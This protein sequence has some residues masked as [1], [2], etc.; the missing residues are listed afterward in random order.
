M[1]SME[2]VGMEVTGPGGKLHSSLHSFSISISKGL[3]VCHEPVGVVTYAKFPCKTLTRSRTTGRML[4]EH[5]TMS[6]SSLKS[7]SPRSVHEGLLGL[8]VSCCWALSAKRVA[9]LGPFLILTSATTFL[10]QDS[11]DR[12][13]FCI[14]VFLN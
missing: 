12:R 7:S 3:G 10:T 11:R 1:G 14:V 4:S 5:S 9:M 6:V 8:P 13:P 2:I